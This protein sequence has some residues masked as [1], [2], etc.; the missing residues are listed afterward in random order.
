MGISELVDH[1]LIN[2]LQQSEN[3]PVDSLAPVCRLPSGQSG[4]AHLFHRSG[5]LDLGPGLA[6]PSPVFMEETR[7]ERL[8]RVC[9][10]YR[11]QTKMQ[12]DYDR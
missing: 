6:W 1:K 9:R 5:G 2:Y 7:R 10:K 3:E 4:C 8:A 12:I 11:G